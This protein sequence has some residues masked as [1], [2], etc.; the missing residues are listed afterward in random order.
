MKNIKKMSLFLIGC[1]LCFA[2]AGCGA[3]F[4]ENQNPEDITLKIY[5]PGD[6]QS[7]TP[8]VMEAVN[9]ILRERI[10]ASIDLQFLDGDFNARM[11]VIMAANEK[12]DISW[13]NR[14]QTGVDK[15][16]FMPLSALIEKEAPGL[17]KAL[18]DF[19]WEAVLRDGE[20]Y[21]VPNLQIHALRQAV[22]FPSEYA[23]KYGIDPAN[24]KTA[25]DIEPFLAKV[26]AGE[27]NVY[28][29]RSGTSLTVSQWISPAY[30]AVSGPVVI[31]KGD[32]SARALLI[33]NTPEYKEAVAK[34]RSWYKKGYIRRD[35]ASVVDDNQDFLAGKYVV[36]ATE[37]KPGL[38]QN[39]AAMFGG[40]VQFTCIPLE[41]AYLKT[42]GCVNTMLAIGNNSRYPAQAIKYL[43]TVN[44]DAAVY[45][46]IAKGIEGR[47]YVK[48][49]DKRVAPIKDSGYYPN[50]DWKFG[51][52]F[53]AYLLEGQAD[54]LWE[55]TKRVNDNAGKSPL[56]GFVV[57]TEPITTELSQYAT[58]KKEFGT[59]ES[60]A[61]DYNIT[62][63]AFIK[64][65][66]DGGTQKLLSEVQRQIDAFLASKK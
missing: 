37:Y 41:E 43:E 64:K 48:Q 16:A 7:D 46:L 27:K 50:A 33:Y 28:P 9:E 1:V 32:P 39:Q 52:Q 63:P 21:G 8:A 61:D 60:G 51:N 55:Q 14:Y 23:E 45:N 34:L 35:V 62:L 4:S 66:E 44:T 54:D 18:P 2:I 30:E 36:T 59:L 40:A 31:R 17:K 5:V 10:G 65:A 11:N 29:Y 56:L 13:I 57:D 24:I 22:I 58:A 19:L 6:K 25:S 38:E 47:H 26:K 12:Y 53:N 3:R 15:G 49:D 42:S 20:I